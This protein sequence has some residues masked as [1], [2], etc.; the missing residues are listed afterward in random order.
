MRNRFYCKCWTFVLALSVLFAVGCNRGGKG[1]AIVQQGIDYSAVA[2]PAFSADSAYQYVAD[3]VACGYRTPGSEGQRRCADYLVGKMR[4]W[5]DTVIVQNFTTT[6]WDGREVPG[7]NIIATINGR[8][9]VEVSKRVL[10][11]AH[12]DSRLWA[13]HDPDK[14]NHRKPFDG[15][16]DGASGVGVLME[17][18][19]AIATQPLD[20][21]VDIIFFDVEDQGVPS[22]ADAYEEDSWCLGSQYWS[23]HPHVPYYTAVYGVLLDMVGTEQP[24]YTKEQVSRNYAGNIM[25][26]MWTVA[27][28]IGYGSIFVNS[29]TD[30]ILDDHY[31][32]NRLA[33][34]PMIDVVQNS[35]GT[36]FFKYWHTMGDN[37]EHVDRNSLKAIG[38]VLLKMLYGDYGVEK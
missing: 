19:R 38:E 5:C 1:N 12:W 33:G 21:A 7:K 8:Q 27:D 37:M 28:A 2:V 9:G 36:S 14:S 34:V 29:E 32:V 3:Q 16:N 4:Q 26:K 22:W 24:R 15:A 20:V 31:Y 18:A 35:R 11:G 10:L 25:N 6:L 17:L 30:P 13:D 23:R